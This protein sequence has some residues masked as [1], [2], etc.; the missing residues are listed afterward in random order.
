MKI[1]LVYRNFSK[2]GGVGKYLVELAQRFV[3]EHEVHLIT[4]WYRHRI[5]SLHVHA[6]P[7]ISKPASFEILSN[8]VKNELT[9]GKLN[10][11]HDFDVVH[12]Q[13]AETFT[14]DVITVHSCPCEWIEIRK[15]ERGLP[16][17]MRP[18]DWVTL[19]IQRCNYKKD[20]YK[21]IIAISEKIRQE[22]L[23][24]YNVPEEDVVVIP[25]GV[26]LEE[27]RH[28]PQ[29]RQEIR[30]LHMINETDIVLLFSGWEFKRKGLEYIIRAIATLKDR[31]I[32]LFVVGKDNPAP[33]Q[34][35][36]SGLGIGK[37]IIF[38]GFVPDIKDYYTASDVFVFPT[39]Y[40]PFGMVITEA[41]ASGLP[42]ITNKIA[43]AAELMTNGYDGLLLDNP[44]DYREIA[45]KINL[46]V[47][48]ENLRRSMGKNARTTAEKYSWDEIAKR[49]L[50][51]YKEASEA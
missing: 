27:F 45:E 35:L 28:N 6:A 34:K 16:F 32:K 10:K 23:W 46:L 20:N 38:T 7:I 4:T 21:K 1:A 36:A 25:H 22:I 49:T 18:A 41:M 47:K 42:V 39:T 29:M 17:T 3:K 26:D 24:Y 5:P 31:N 8:A 51:V 15:K 30:K 2:D 40:E 48:D 37:S 43:G 14:Q 13:C 9:V 50:V 44:R 19:A 12:S 33:Y 11:N